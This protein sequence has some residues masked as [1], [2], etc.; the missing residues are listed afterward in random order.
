MRVYYRE[1]WEIKD[2]KLYLFGAWILGDDGKWDYADLES[3]FG[4]WHIDDRVEAV[5]FTGELHLND[6]NKL[7]HDGYRV[8]YERDMVIKIESG[9]I[10]GKEIIDNRKK[11]EQSVKNAPLFQAIENGNLSEVRSLLDKGADIN[12]EDINTELTPL[13]T[14]Y[15][16]GQGEIVELLIE[17]GA[18]MNFKM[19]TVAAP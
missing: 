16:N 3:L 12:A 18:D 11:L 10:V 5:W 17:M 9:K 6:G 15:D 7:D 2:G 13:I 14:A 19:S 4:D 8:I 1:K